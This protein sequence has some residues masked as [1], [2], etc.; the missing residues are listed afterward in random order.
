M[1]LKKGKFKAETLVFTTS[2]SSMSSS[3]PGTGHCSGQNKASHLE[4]LTF[5]RRGT[6]NKQNM[7]F[8]W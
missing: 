1:H 2:Q 8:R 6:N 3:V 5:W 7:G 4:E